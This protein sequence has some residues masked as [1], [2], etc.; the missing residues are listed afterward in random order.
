MSEDL[1]SQQQEQERELDPDHSANEDVGQHKNKEPVLLVNSPRNSYLNHQEP[2][3]HY[4][5]PELLVKKAQKI[6]GQK[7]KFCCAINKD[8]MMHKPVYLIED[9]TVLYDEQN[10]IM[11]LSQHDTNPKTG[12]KL[13]SKEFKVNTYVLKEIDAY[14]KKTC[15]KSMDIVEQL[16]SQGKSID[17][18]IA[19]LEKCLV[20]IPEDEEFIYMKTWFLE[21]LISLLCRTNCT[22]EESNSR[23]LEYR[24]TLFAI[25]QKHSMFTQLTELAEE[26]LFMD[27]LYKKDEVESESGSTITIL[28]SKGHIMEMLIQIYHHTKNRAK[29]YIWLEN[30]VQA[31]DIYKNDEFLNNQVAELASTVKSGVIPPKNLVFS[32]FYEY[33]LLPSLSELTQCLVA[34]QRLIVNEEHYHVLEFCFKKLIRE[35]LGTKRLSGS[36]VNSL[37][38]SIINDF[39]ELKFKF[40]SISEFN[41]RET[42]ELLKQAIEVDP[43]NARSL[44]HIFNLIPTDNELSPVF[45]FVW[46]RLK[47]SMT[48]ND[49]L[50]QEIVRLRKEIEDKNQKLERVKSD[51]TKAVTELNKEIAEYKH[52]VKSHLETQFETILNNH[53]EKKCKYKLVIPGLVEKLETE[54]EF[55]TDTFFMGD[56]QWKLKFQVAESTHTTTDSQNTWIGC[57]LIL[58]N[59]LVAKEN[60]FYS[61]TAKCRVEILSNKRVAKVHSNWKSPELGFDMNKVGYGTDRLITLHDLAKIQTPEK[62]TIVQVRCTMHNG[63]WF[64]SETLQQDY[65]T[66]KWS[67]SHDTNSSTTKQFIL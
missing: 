4:E 57:Y 25:Y 24:I 52:I 58:V 23:Q 30:Y 66:N 14:R 56:H 50:G 53:T 54:E 34:S 17:V 39:V 16:Y 48:R 13:E 1:K 45:D 33:P 37:L 27:H 22:N 20:I 8:Q 61:L 6:I 26:T 46:D 65:F 7:P 5:S 12:N 28:R 19:L 47:V 18:C 60:L 36:N 9:E 49:Q 51:N 3:D 63:C 62:Q 67:E 32:L 10:L 43:M 40:S 35:Q 44:E 2:R 29:W 64:E 55:T 42:F 59:N 41:L 21:S 11:W 31:K 38:S 15:E